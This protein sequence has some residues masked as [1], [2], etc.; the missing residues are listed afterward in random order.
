MKI[1]ELKTTPKEK[2]DTTADT[3]KRS[4]P[5]TG[6]SCA[7]CASSVETILSNKEG[8]KSASV[9]FASNTVQVEYDE[10]LSP[11]DLQ[12]TLREVGYDIIT[13]TDNAEEKQQEAQREYYL[14]LKR[15]T[16]L[17]ALFTLPVFILGMFFMGWEPGKWISAVLAIPVMTWAGGNFFV[18]AL[19][20]A[21]Y[22]K[23]NMDTLVALSTGIAFTFSLINTLFPQWLLTKG[24]E[25][26]V[27]Y[28]AATVIIT[29]IL[30]GRLLEERAKS[31]TSSALRKLIGLQPKT[32]IALIN[33]EEKEMPLSS[34]ERGDQIV[35]RPGDKIPVDGELNSGSS[36]VDE[37]MISGEPV[38][39]RKETGHTVYAGTINQK[40]SF[41][42]KAS[43]VG[44]ETLLAHIIQMVQQAQGSK[45][46][47][48]K[49]ADRVA[50]I[51]VPIVM[52]IAAITFIIWIVAGGENA[53]THALLTSV[54]VLVIACPC[55][56]GLATPTAVMVGMGK[57]AEN[58]ILI[59]DAESLELGHK[60]DTVVLDKTG[61]ITEGKP[62][63]SELW[64]APGKSNDGKSSDLSISQLLSMELKSEHPIAE[65]V[66]RKLREDGVKSVDVT[67]F[68]SITGRGVIAR[69]SQ[70]N[71][72]LA[73]NRQLLKDWGIEL[74]EEVEKLASE[75]Q[76]EA[77]TVIF[78]ASGEE[79]IAM[80]RITDRIKKSSPAAISR[81][82]EAGIEVHMLTGDNEQTAAAVAGQVGI[83]KY[84]SGLMP[85]DKADY[86]IKLQEE[87]RIVAMVGDGI[88]DS[89][90]LAQADVSIAMG[91]G[92]D[93]AM[94]VAK[95]TL[96]TSD[97]ESLPRAFSLSKKTV[98]GIRQNLF[99]A[100]FYNALGIPIAAGILYPLN[101]FLLDPMIA[102]AAM[103]FSSVSVVTNSLRLKRM[104]I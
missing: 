54:A 14:S 95:I 100:F 40:G 61:T 22:G 25:P 102:A 75:W 98:R 16:I 15:K 46:P 37:S 93:I 31:S 53:L 83:K 9:N 29:V 12:K 104:K 84:L 101:G 50:G 91:H 80:L 23:A 27:Y 69:D 11:E 39:V 72:I 92:S 77:A 28:E 4:F 38:P 30:L 57:G 65:A 103:A 63:V 13:E 81:L 88:N 68:E 10:S 79:L 51:F 52:T 71:L 64:M 89:Q 66:V 42:L 8:V 34:V 87:G 70:N 19:K 90:A 58:N 35:V 7:A 43:K 94:D 60:V 55:A 99:W 33:G 18:N 48:Q 3:I 56:L 6:M 85:S 82:N 26:H 20:Q 62:A 32:V 2:T 21:R 45:A 96:M 41:V 36:W 73:G 76:S 47:V 78:F 24:L 44:D 74:A 86:V 67:D 5:V 17:S 97:L 49:L 59:R 1:K